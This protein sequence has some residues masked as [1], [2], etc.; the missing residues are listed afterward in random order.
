MAPGKLHHG[1]S[2][3]IDEVESPSLIFESGNQSL[4]IRYTN[5]FNRL[6]SQIEDKGLTHDSIFKMKKKITKKISAD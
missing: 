2:I 1:Y 3:D 5:V 4:M 6:L